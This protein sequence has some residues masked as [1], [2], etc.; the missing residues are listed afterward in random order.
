[1]CRDGR[2]CVEME[3]SVQRWKGVCRDGWGV[4]RDGRECVEM[5]GSVQRWK[6][7]CTDGWGVCRDG[8]ECVETDGEWWRWLQY[9]RFSGSKVVGHI[10]TCV[11]AY[12][13]LRVR[14]Y[15]YPNVSNFL[16]E[17][18]RPKFKTKCIKHMHTII[19]V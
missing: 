18:K 10:H 6:G 7:V 12:N 11:H 2:E 19:L 4:C 3:G 17:L 5:E 9:S 13:A 14:T 15:T 16:H 8:R 1:M